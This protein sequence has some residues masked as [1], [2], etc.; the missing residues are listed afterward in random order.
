MKPGCAN[1]GRD[2]DRLSV[3]RGGSPE[4]GT[5]GVSEALSTCFK[6]SL[7]QGSLEHPQVMFVLVAGHAV[8][9]LDILQ[10]LSEAR[11]GHCHILKV[12][13]SCLSR[14]RSC[15]YVWFLQA[16]HHHRLLCQRRC[17]TVIEIATLLSLL[18]G[19]SAGECFFSFI[20]IL[21]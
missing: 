11:T 18:T 8:P 19:S 1:R 6:S 12:A 7:H 9:E 20:I 10:Q 4:V 3:I 5:P 21:N 14:P 2:D 15:L 16:L 13:N 17:C